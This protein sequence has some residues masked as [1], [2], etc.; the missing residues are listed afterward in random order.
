ME[1][2]APEAVGFS[3]KRLNRINHAM[4][5]HIDQGRFPGIATIVAR[6]G[7]IAHAESVGWMDLEDKKTMRLDAI[8]RLA[9]MTKPIT[10]TAVMMLYERGLFQ[11]DDPVSKFIPEFLSQ[12]VY[13][14]FEDG[15][16]QLTDTKRDITIGDLLSFVSGLIESFNTDPPL[17]ELIDSA[18]TSSEDTLDKRANKLAKLPLLH[19]PGQAWRYGPDYVV[20]ARLV[21][22]ISGKSFADF[23]LDEIFEPLNMQDTGFYVTEEKIRRVTTLYDYSDSTQP[24][25]ADAPEKC[26]VQP[27]FT[28]GSGNLLSTAYDYL[29]FAQMLLNGGELEGVRLLSRKTVEF[30]TKNHLSGEL[31]PIGIDD[32]G[33]SWPGYGYGMGF[34]VVLDVA[35]T[36]LLGSSG[37]YGWAG[38]CS[39]YFWI[40][41]KEE[42]IGIFMSHVEPP[43]YWP[44]LIATDFKVLVYQAIA[45]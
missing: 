44:N 10:S 37:E 35:Q 4:Q 9:S 31:L 14:G 12:K 17:K 2:T 27:T 42:L 34:R 1:T 39:T 22:V 19:Q 6:K 33:A 20:L 36:Q 7:Q 21:E 8:F 23:L 38:S 15:K 41:P 26:L 45:D 3:S 18:N 43:H 25:V 40:D 5:A 11:L 13:T 28:S 16:I 32:F 24:K 30:M 29:R